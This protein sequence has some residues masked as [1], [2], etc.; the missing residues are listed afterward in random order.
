MMLTATPDDQRDRA[1]AAA[2]AA[3]D[4]AAQEAARQAEE[5]AAAEAR[6]DAANREAAAQRIG[7][8]LAALGAPITLTGNA[9]NESSAW[10]IVPGLPLTTD[11]GGRL[12]KLDW[13]EPIL[14][15]ATLGA[16][17]RDHQAFERQ[18]KAAV[19][20]E[21]KCPRPPFKRRVFTNNTSSQGIILEAHETTL[22][23]GP[24]A[25]HD[26]VDG[27][28]VIFWLLNVTA[29][30]ARALAGAIISA[31]LRREPRLITLTYGGPVICAPDALTFVDDERTLTISLDVSG[32]FRDEFATALNDWAQYAD[33]TRAWYDEGREVAPDIEF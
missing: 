28:G 32:T 29:G 33:D 18:Q 25:P 22:S 10:E 3:A 5:T 16:V 17:I 4:K 23:I 2:F 31:A 1:I 13:W 12:R 6:Q 19:E 9:L 15:L 24:F 26:G 11:N 21:Q 20:L 27:P 7:A 30:M 14:S 8:A